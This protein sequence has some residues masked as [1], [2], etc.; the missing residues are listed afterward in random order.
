MIM[1]LQYKIAAN[2]LLTEHGELKLC[3]FG[4]SG[5]V[6]AKSTKRTTFVG[7]P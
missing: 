4:V 3:D 7:T 2:I 6:N 5:S 1:Y